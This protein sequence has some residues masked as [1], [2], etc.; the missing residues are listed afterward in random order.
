MT[1]ERAKRT[2]SLGILIVVGV[3][4]VMILLVAVTP[5]TST[6]AT[7]NCSGLGYIG[8]ATAASISLTEAAYT[9]FEAPTVTTSE[10]ITRDYTH[11]NRPLRIDDAVDCVWY[12]EMS[13]S[14]DDD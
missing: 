6:L 2:N 10:Q 5:T 8:E 9:G 11:A 14:M 1:H 3:G 13:G 12:V 4:V 7:G